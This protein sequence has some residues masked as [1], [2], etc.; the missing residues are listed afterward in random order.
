MNIRALLETDYNE[1]KSL[2]T[3]QHIYHLQHRPDLFQDI[4]EALTYDEFQKFI[5]GYHTKVFVAEENKH[6]LGYITLLDREVIEDGFV[7]GYRYLLIDNIY[8]SLAYRKHHIGTF[9]MKQAQSYAKEK[10]YSRIE[11]QVFGF[12]DAAIQ[13]YESLGYTCKYMMMEKITK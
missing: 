2:Y 3:E 5:E 6:L 1:L 13:F 7:R 10:D 9:L 4:D 11:L 8:V 12:N